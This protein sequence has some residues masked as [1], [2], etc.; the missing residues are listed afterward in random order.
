M[1]SHSLNMKTGMKTF[2]LLLS[3]F[4][5]FSEEVGRNDCFG[6]NSAW[7]KGNPNPNRPTAT[8]S[9]AR[10]NVECQKYHFG[11][12]ISTLII[13]HNDMD[14]DLVLA[15]EHSYHG[16]WYWLPFHLRDIKIPAHHYGSLLHTKSFASLYGSEGWMKFKTEDDEVVY[17][18]FNTPYWGTNQIGVTVCPKNWWSDEGDSYDV[19]RREIRTSS[20][21]IIVTAEFLR[22]VSSPHV[23]FTVKKENYS[24]SRSILTKAKDHCCAF[25]C[26][27]DCLC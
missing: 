14:E 12:G 8:L 26:I 1:S 19:H 7:L 20:H 3:I 27:D 10:K 21:K 13:I 5:S 17:F 9:K 11:N 16:E 23:K 18:E 22:D 2:W 4:V 15:D 24:G 6:L 25:E